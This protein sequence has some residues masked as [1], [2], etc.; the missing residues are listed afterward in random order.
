MPLPALLLVVFLVALLTSL[1]VAARLTHVVVSR[2]EPEASRQWSDSTIPR[3]GG[4]AVFAAIPVAILAAVFGRAALLG[5]V[6]E[7]PERAGA[8]IISAAILFAVGLRDDIKRVSPIV[9]LAAQTGA[10]L[11][12]CGSGFSIEHVRLVPGHTLDLGVLS[13]PVTV[14]WLVGISNAFNLIDGID[15]LAGGVAII[16]LISTVAAA[17]FLGNPTVPIYTIALVGALI[18]FLRYNWPS[19]RLLMG[20]SGSLVVG[21]LLAVFSVKAATDQRHLTYGLVP[22]FALAYPLLDTGIAML[23]RWLRGV[24]LSRADRRHIHHQLRSLGLGPTKALIAIYS[25]SIVV[26]G[27]G[28]LAAFAPPAVTLITT[29]LGIVALFAIIVFSVSWLEYHEFSEAGSSLANA[30][31]S[32]PWVIRD[33]INARDLAAV[34]LKA[35]TL[36]EVQ[37]VLEQSASTFRFAHMKLGTPESRHRTPG[38]QTQELQ[39]LKLWKLEYPIVHGNTMDYYGLCLTIWC[40]LGKSQH[41]VGAERIAEMVGP[42]IAEWATS[43]KLRPADVPA[44]GDRLLRVPYS[45]PPSGDISIEHAVL[46]LVTS[47]PQAEQRLNA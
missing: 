5:V 29:I 39:M 47:D 26:A 4:V 42:A 18:G 24:P 1:G 25:A 44:Y 8:L 27:L 43:G 12:I 10:A 22:I 6:P 37:N 34:I 9:K 36:E 17:L 19:A 45:P 41:P 20:D 3:I 15:G 2:R 35:E 23:R 14:L 38:R 21:F 7:M 28:L 13:L 46:A 30:A 40:D 11:I 33:K 16:G 32:A 31:R